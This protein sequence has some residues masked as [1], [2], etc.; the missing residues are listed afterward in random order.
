MKKIVFIL[1]LLIVV[2]VYLFIKLDG[3]GDNYYLYDDSGPFVGIKYK[4]KYIIN[5]EVIDF[6]YNNDFI[7]AYRRIYL[8]DGN[9]GD[10]YYYY[11]NKSEYEYWIIDK[12]NHNYYGHLSYIEYIN[13]RKELSISDKLN[14]DTTLAT[15]PAKTLDN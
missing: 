12:E 9:N 2:V 3:L 13:K 1:F 6:D 11:K 7:I 4:D 15:Q 14:L 5:F 10:D 8:D